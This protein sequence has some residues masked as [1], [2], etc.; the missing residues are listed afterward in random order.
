MAKFKYK[1]RHNNGKQTSGFVEAE[2]K[3]QAIQKLKK[4]DIYPT[5]VVIEGLGN[6][7]FNIPNP[8][9]SVTPRDLSAFCR[10]FQTMAKAGISIVEILDIL[11]KQSE[12]K[13]MREKLDVL[14]QD[15]QKGIPLSRSMQ[16]YTDVFPKLLVNMVQSGEVSGQLDSIMD[17]MAI[18]FE[19]EDKINQKIKGALIYPI[20]L[21]VVA[22]GVI[23]ILVIFVVPSYMSMFADFGIEM[24]LITLLLYNTGLFMKKNLLL[25]I[26]GTLLAGYGFYRFLK[27]DE[28]AGMFDRFK[29]KL[30]VVGSVNKKIVTMR[31][32]RTLSTMLSSGVP[33]I[34]AMETIAGVL[35]NTVFIKAVENTLDQVKKGEGIAKPLESVNLF[36][37]LLVSMIRI[38]EETGALDTM[39]DTTADYYDDEV[40]IAIESMIKLIEPMII[41][42][43]A[44]V[45]GGILL[46]IITPMIKL[47]TDLNI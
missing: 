27:T 25:L 37:P 7:E 15:V 17:R 21:T 41:L 22:I 30:P 31:F 29:L 10:Q 47:Y 32:A 5:Q 44:F 28:G 20:A 12:K 2:T 3:Q 19:K 33:I 16:R 40:D 36:P 9:N 34:D 11:R 6:R 14:F 1:G 38:G 45:V 8:F 35:G 43:M 42:V 26:I 46:S 24:P 4:D 39:L 23:L 13:A 18:H